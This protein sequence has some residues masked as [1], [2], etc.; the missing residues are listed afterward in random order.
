MAPAGA[1][2]K[3]AR[4]GGVPQAFQY[5]G[6]SAADVV[7]LDGFNPP[8]APTVDSL[9]I[10]PPLENLAV[11]VASRVSEVPLAR[12]RSE[13]PLAAGLRTA[14]LRLQSTEVFAPQAGDIPIAETAQGPVILAR[15]GKPKIVVFGFHPMRS[16]MRYELA[17]PLLF[18]NI[19]RWMA[20]QIFRRWELNAGSVGSV[21]ATLDPDTDLS[22]LRVLAENGAPLPFT[23][24]DRVVRLF[25]GVPGT[26]RVI[27]GDREQVYSLTL[28]EVADAKWLPPPSVKRGLGGVRRAG[29]A[30]KDLWQLLALLAGLGLLLD[31]LLFG[32]RKSASPV[33][34]PSLW[35]AQNPLL[36]L[37][38]GRR[39]AAGLARRPS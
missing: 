30:S 38:R 18:A 28:P 23:V 3:S 4:R 8:S 2:R 10:E 26:V 36:R 34:G 20:P 37:W 22:Q 31:W 11:K 14:D 13:F 21:K 5:G 9:W 29:V 27:A 12:W 33:V 15:P 24:R 17:T 7:I 32:Q 35:N 19:L 6:A 25:S 16:A 1:G 39:S